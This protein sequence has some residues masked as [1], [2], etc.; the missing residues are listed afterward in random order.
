MLLFILQGSAALKSGFCNNV[1]FAGCMQDF[2]KSFKNF[3]YSFQS[4][5]VPAINL[6]ICVKGF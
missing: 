2:G 6:E 3:E 4:K 1:Y 5:N